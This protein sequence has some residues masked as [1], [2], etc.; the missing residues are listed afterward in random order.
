[1]ELLEHKHPA[2]LLW[3]MHSS[4]IVTNPYAAQP[5]PCPWFPDPIASSPHHPSVG[6]SFG[7]KN[8]A[9]GEECL[10]PKCKPTLMRQ[11]ISVSHASTRFISKILSLSFR[12]LKKHNQITNPLDINDNKNQ[13]V[14][15]AANIYTFSREEYKICK[16]MLKE[17]RQSTLHHSIR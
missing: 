17:F 6:K 12:N 7:I 14:G 2:S 1:M 16:Y 8:C 3:F 11:G 13:Q 15:R 10:H 4:S 5:Q 9:L